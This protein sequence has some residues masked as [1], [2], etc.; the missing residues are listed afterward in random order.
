MAELRDRNLASAKIQS[1][2]L[3]WFSLP[4]AACH[5]GGRNSIIADRTLDREAIEK[6]LAGGFT[7]EAIEYQV[8]NGKGAMPAWQDILDEDEIKDVAEY[9]YTT[10]KANGWPR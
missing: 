8:A 4:A 1:I 7:M 10:A 5:L 2:D 9:V 3:T 6:Y